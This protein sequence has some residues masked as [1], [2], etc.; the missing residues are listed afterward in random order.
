[1]NR[2]VVL[3]GL[4]A[5]CAVVLCVRLGIW[6]LSRLDERRAKN[7]L[8]RERGQAPAL[9]LR[10]IRDQD[11][12]A[13]HWHRVHV[14]GVAL[15]DDELVQSSR[16]QSGAPGVY[17][18]TPIRPLDSSWGDTVVLLLRGFVYAANGR[19]IDFAA[20]READTLSFDALVTAF[21]PAQAGAVQSAASPRSVRALNRD[22]ISAV[23]HRPL[24]PV[25]LLVLGDTMPHEVTRPSRIPP[26]SLSE[27]PHQS[28][29]YQWFTFAF[30]FFA[31]FIAFV[32]N[33]KR[34]SP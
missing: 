8:V 2:R 23:M 26:P 29:A 6:Q 27:G 1:M 24:A 20:A 4:F 18:L 21:S 30:I 33:G 31:G 19:T 34:A 3:F 25:V 14:R 16:S 12:S 15:Y 11:T 22:S 28:Y 9:D 32:V 13:T 5:L 7:A 10:A 17:L